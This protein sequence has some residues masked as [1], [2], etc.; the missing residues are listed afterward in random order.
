MKRILTTLILLLLSVL[1]SA[2]RTDQIMT[3]KQIVEQP[4]YY[5]GYC[6]TKARFCTV[7]DEKELVILVEDEGYQIPICLQNKDL[8][9]TTR[10]QN[11]NL[12]QGNVIFIRGIMAKNI[13][14]NDK[15]Y[16]GLNNATIIPLNESGIPIGMTAVPYD[17]TDTKPI[18]TRND[19]DFDGWVQSKVR[20]PIKMRKKFASGNVTVNF[21]IDTDGKVKSVDVQKTSSPEF[22]KEAHRV[23]SRSPKWTPGALNGKNVPVLYRQDVKI[24]LKTKK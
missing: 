5:S 19:G 6:L 9:A 17:L 12:Q 7:Y 20:Y 8:A 10:F 21:V 14:V 1:C 22:N 3:I 15:K 11:L 16:T 2:Q 18:F 13:K 4:V 24:E 23:I